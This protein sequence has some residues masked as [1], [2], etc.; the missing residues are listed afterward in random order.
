[1]LA[2]PATS[3]SEVPKVPGPNVQYPETSTEYVT[4]TVGS[5]TTEPVKLVAWN[6][7]VESW[8]LSA[9]AAEPTPNISPTRSSSTRMPLSVGGCSMTTGTWR[10]FENLLDGGE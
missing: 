1:M 10:L 8:P 6:N 9:V 2:P 4:S 5:A 7:S 3:M